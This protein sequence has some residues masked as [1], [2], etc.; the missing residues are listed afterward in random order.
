MKLRER[1]EAA[2]LAPECVGPAMVAI[3]EWLHEKG[4]PG[5]RGFSPHFAFV[6][7]ELATE[8]LPVSPPVHHSS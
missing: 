7:T 8:E 4:G 2:G 6:F 3:G 1:L 5:N